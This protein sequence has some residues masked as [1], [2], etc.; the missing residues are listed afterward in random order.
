MESNGCCHQQLKSSLTSARP[1]IVQQSVFLIR[2]IDTEIKKLVL[3]GHAVVSPRQPKQR[4][5]KL[6][7][8]RDPPFQLKPKK[9]AQLGPKKNIEW[10]IKKSPAGFIV[11]KQ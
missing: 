4:H 11:E 9:L 3:L 7:E 2:W 8:Y 1:P 5:A 10:W 6:S